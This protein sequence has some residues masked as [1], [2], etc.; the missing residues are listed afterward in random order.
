MNVIECN[1]LTKAYF[2][3]NVLNGL[4]FTIEENKI[5][6]LIGRNGV[7]KTTL[8]KIL[9]GLIKETSGEVRVFEQ[10]PFNNLYTSANT[11]LVDDQMF[12]PPALQ[13]HELLEVAQSFYP[14]WDME[15]AQRLLQYF[16]FDPSHYHQTLSKGRTSTFN[17][18]IGLASRCSL[19]ILDEPTTGMD[20]AVRKDFYRALMKDYLAHPRT[21]L[22]SS[23][24][25]NEIEDILEDVLLIKNGK[26]LLHESISDLKE[27]A[28]ALQGASTVV[29]KWL[30]ER[31]CIFQRQV[32]KD[33][34]YAVVRD[35]FTKEN[36]EEALRGGVE[37][38]P[39][40]ASDLCVYLTND[41]KGGI[42]DVFER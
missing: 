12:F 21:I 22:I 5:T 15:L 16:S 14:N 29:Q 11:I 9:A 24:H 40:K 33:T 10:H 28:I 6:G 36:K 41:T 17:M 32:G 4:T 38:I 8:V 19:T 26:T 35:D 25:L 42:D 2:R 7:G 37:F 30:V 34:L 18:I 13:L 3:K 27:W 23:H 39:V 20:E 1:G 31:N